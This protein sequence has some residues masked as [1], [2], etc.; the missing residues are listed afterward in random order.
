MYALCPALEWCKLLMKY[1]LRRGLKSPNT[2]NGN[3][4]FNIQ[5]IFC[6]NMDVLIYLLRFCFIV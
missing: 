4:S 1:L 2:Q 3:S 5:D 6:P